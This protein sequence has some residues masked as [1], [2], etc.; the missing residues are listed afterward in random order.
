MHSIAHR[1]CLLTLLLVGLGLAAGRADA[2]DERRALR[3]PSLT[4]D[5]KQVVFCYRG[6]VWIAPLDGSHRAD[7]LT[8]H[9]EQE[10]LTRVSP[11]GKHVAFSSN[12]GGGYDLYVMPVTGGEPRQVTFHSTPEILCNW[13]P[14]GKKLLFM[15]NRDANEARYDL[16][17]VDISGKGTP[18]R[19]TF[20]G[21]RDGSYS[22]DGMLPIG[23]GN[24]R[25]LNQST[26]SSVAYSTL[27]IFF[28]Y[29]V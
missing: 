29:C 28:L 24:L 17:E 7:R 11:D 18:R 22:A 16:Y 21:A 2:K 23:Y 15:S 3:Y 10:T 26:H 8:I 5:G 20:D 19:L 6:D 1:I 14:D 13:S 4:P 9:E 12:R 25:L 27:S